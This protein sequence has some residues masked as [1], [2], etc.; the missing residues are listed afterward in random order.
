MDREVW[1]LPGFDVSRETLDRLST[2]IELLKKWNPA[3]NLVA[4]STI[5]DAWNRHIVDSAQLFSAAPTKEGRWLDLGSGGGFPGL[6]CA[7]LAAE[8]APAMDFTLV[9]SDQRKCAFLRTAA[10]AVGLNVKILSDRIESLPPQGA[11][12]VSA[13]ALAP[14]D[15]LLDLC[16]PHLVP[17]AYSLFP[18]GNRHSEEVQA[19]KRHW[20]FKM[21]IKPSITDPK[22]VILVCGDIERV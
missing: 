10:T 21:E 22:G 9:E 2:H 7:I 1:G 17:G 11:H 15:R 8:L 4:K 14:L 16:E 18:K 20:R 19:A 13:R 3:I 6:V 12:I 5:E